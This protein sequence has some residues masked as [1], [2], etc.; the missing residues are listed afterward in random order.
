MILTGNP[1]LNIICGHY[2]SGK[3]NVA[4]NL[5][6]DLRKHAKDLHILAADLDIVNPYFRTAD[7]AEILRKAEEGGCK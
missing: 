5:A 7:A 6:L 3:T 4:V 2:G 1:K